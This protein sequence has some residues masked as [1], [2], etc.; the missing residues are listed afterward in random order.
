M[1]MWNM[2]PAQNPDAPARTVAGE[3]VVI[4]PHDSVIHSLNET[5]TFVWDR[6]DGRKTLA[7]ILEEFREVFDV[8]L[9]VLEADVSNFVQEAQARGMLSLHEAP[10][11]I[12][13]YP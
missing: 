12:D 4:T 6:A 7:A 13:V 11:P 5:A 1:T 10:H 9:A 8:E 3:A 2:Y